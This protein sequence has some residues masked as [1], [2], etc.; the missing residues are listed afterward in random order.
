MAE[1]YYYY[2]LALLRKWSADKTDIFGADIVDQAE[3]QLPGT[4]VCGD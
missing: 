1:S 3:E 4:E 2:G